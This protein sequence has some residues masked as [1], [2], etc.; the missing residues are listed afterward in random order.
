MHLGRGRAQCCLTEN[1]Q[2]FACLSLPLQKQKFGSKIQTVRSSEHTL[3][4][5][6]S[7][8]VSHDWPARHRQRS[9]G[10][11]IARYIPPRSVSLPARTFIYFLGGAEALRSAAQSCRVPR[12]QGA[13][14]AQQ[15]HT[16][17]GGQ[18]R[19]AQ[20]GEPPRPRSVPHHTRPPRAQAP[21]LVRD[22]LRLAGGGLGLGGAP[23]QHGSSAALRSDPLRS[24]PP[25]AATP[26]AVLSP[27]R[28]WQREEA[29]RGV[30]SSQ[31]AVGS[32]IRVSL[33][34]FLPPRRSL[35][36]AGVYLTGAA[37]YLP[38]LAHSERLEIS[39]DTCVQTNLSWGPGWQPCCPCKREHVLPDMQLGAV[40]FRFLPKNVVWRSKPA[41]VS[42][43]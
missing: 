30:G 23:A 19:C 29:G 39:E 32:C 36:L 12:G 28:T 27:G 5:S 33:W 2:A 31:R 20:P 34:N 16:A 22:L 21:H 1:R 40:K 41:G 11:R 3:H 7:A 37:P 18:Q 17:P 25:P 15:A 13:A 10:F 43:H 9:G 38:G 26:V 14:P 8:R 35:C 4:T 6:D 42:E 24:D